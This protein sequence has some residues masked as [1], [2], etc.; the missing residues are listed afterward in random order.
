MQQLSEVQ[1]VPCQLAKLAFFTGL[2]AVFR[3]SDI[4][5]DGLATTVGHGLHRLTQEL[6]VFYS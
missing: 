4:L 5:L 1:S 6:W 3:F 2:I